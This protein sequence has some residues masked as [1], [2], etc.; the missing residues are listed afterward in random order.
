MLEHFS[1]LVEEYD[2][3]PAGSVVLCAVSGGGDS[4][5]LLALLKGMEAARGITVLAAHF[6][7]RLRGADSDGDQIFVADWCRANGI[8]LYTGSG[9]VAAAAK[10]RGQGVEETARALRYAFLRSTAAAV[11]AT[12]IATAHHADDNAET[13]LLNL[14]RGTGLQG[15]TGIPP[16]RGEVVRPLLTTPRSELAEYLAAQGIPHREDATNTDTSFARNR[17]RR[18]VLPILREMNPRVTEHMTDTLRYLRADNDFLNARAAEACLAAREA[19]D[20]LIISA[21]AIGGLPA[22]VAPRAA[23][24]LLER[25]G[26]GEMRCTAGHLNAIVD[27][28]RSAD[29]SGMV[30]L[31]GGLLAQRVYGELLL[32]TREEPPPGFPPVPLHVGENPIPG[33]GWT[34]TLS[35]VTPGLVARPRAQGDRLTLPGRGTKTVKKLLIDAK[36]PRRVREQIPVLADR[37][38]LLA[39]AGFGR[40]TAHPGYETIE[41]ALTQKQNEDG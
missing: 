39:V 12:R 5:C 24:Q 28:C 29:P 40:N 17:L 9:D 13:L 14:L 33:T 36:I 27:L 34:A 41:I 25:M 35:A 18:E 37:D 1:A 15:L 21:A 6:N 16:R 26:D 7:H 38:G 8:P 4:M 3:L 23:R 22:A 32:T 10:A 19:G 31:P 30:N 2:M 20:D 11:H